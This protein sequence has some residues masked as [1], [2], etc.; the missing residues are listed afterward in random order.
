MKDQKTAAIN[1]PRYAKPGKF[2]SAE[3]ERHIGCQSKN[4]IQDEMIVE[5]NMDC[6]QYRDVT[7]SQQREMTK[8][9]KKAPAKHKVK[10]SLSNPGLN[11]G[12]VGSNP[13]DANSTAI[14]AVN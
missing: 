4:Q 9:G 13:Y 3:C 7:G 6:Q 8:L 2:G 14:Q 10:T 11:P 5:L 1:K 12:R